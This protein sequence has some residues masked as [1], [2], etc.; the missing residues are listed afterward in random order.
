MDLVMKTPRPDNAT[1]H[2]VL[3]LFEEHSLRFRIMIVWEHTP[4]PLDRITWVL[5]G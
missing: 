5:L 2:M 3:E 1:I 4:S